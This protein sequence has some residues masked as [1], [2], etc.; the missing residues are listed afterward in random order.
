V[1]IVLPFSTSKYLGCSHF[2][3]KTATLN[4]YHCKTIFIDIM[5]KVLNTL[6]LCLFVCCLGAQNKIP[7]G[8]NPAAGGKVLANGVEI[9]YEK[10]GAGKPL[11]LLHGNGGS[12]GARWREIPEFSKRYQV[13][14]I[15]SRCHGK[16]GCPE[17]DLNY[18]QMAA[19]LNVVLEHLKID[20]CLIWGQSDGG[21]LALIMGYTYPNKVKKMA[22]SGVNV[23]PDSSAL[24]PELV[25]LCQMY[26]MVP[27]LLLRK[28]IKLTAEH[29]HI[30]FETLHQVKAPVLVIAGDRDAIREE[31]T[32]KIFQALPQAQLC[33]LPGATHFHAA[34]KPAL[35]QS[36]VL[37]FFEKPFAMPSTV[38]MM[39]GYAQQMLGKK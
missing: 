11:L 38:E 24:F 19:D 23:Q 36:I 8:N 4:T 33:I 37:D 15:D 22:I 3:L 20:S 27:N 12:I 32:L 6:L 14:A 21:I 35:F 28:Q 31:H 25:K 2:G 26:P 18:E 16:S 1:R 7:Y 34:E 39:K 9:Y 30:S 29:P 17:G 10:Y 13:I 5:K